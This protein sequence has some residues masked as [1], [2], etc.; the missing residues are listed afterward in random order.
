MHHAYTASLQLASEIFGSK[1]TPI[2]PVPYIP[3]ISEACGAI[4]ASN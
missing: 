2:L 4:I 1:N 3:Y